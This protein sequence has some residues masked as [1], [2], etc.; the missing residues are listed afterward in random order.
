MLRD[1][2]EEKKKVSTEVS[3]DILMQWVRRSLNRA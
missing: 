3:I 2:K 1:R